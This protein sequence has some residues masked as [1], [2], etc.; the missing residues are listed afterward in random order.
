MNKV[1]EHFSCN[2]WMVLHTSQIN[3]FINNYNLVLK[4]TLSWN[5]AVKQRHEKDSKEYSV[6][7]TSPINKYHI[8]EGDAIEMCATSSIFNDAFFFKIDIW[9]PEQVFLHYRKGKL[10]KKYEEY[11]YNEEDFINKLGEPPNFNEPGYMKLNV[12]NGYDSYYY[13]LLVMD[14][15]GIDQKNMEQNME[16]DSHIYELP[17]EIINKIKNE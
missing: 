7:I 4:E 14:S 15:L 5:N 17:I 2:T 9:C 8:I 13:P 16:K 11:V 12:D 6:I 10:I 3:D 1:I